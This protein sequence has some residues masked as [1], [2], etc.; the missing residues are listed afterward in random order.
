MPKELF[1]PQSF[2]TSYIR[3]AKH[4]PK[5]KMLNSLSANVQKIA[6]ITDGLTITPAKKQQ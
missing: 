4:P 5:C 3:R 6:H 1:G 2:T